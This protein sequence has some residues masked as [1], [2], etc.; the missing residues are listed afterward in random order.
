MSVNKQGINVISVAILLAFCAVAFHAQ[1]N[2][3][4]EAEIKVLEANVAT[5]AQAKD[6]DAVMKNFVPD[7]TL[8]VFDVIPPRQCVGA[9]SFKKNWQGFLDGFKGPVTVENSDLQVFADGKLAY[10]HY[11]QHVAGTGKDGKPI[12]ITFRMTDVLRKI[13]G[14]WLIV[15]E[16]VSVP[17]DIAS[18]KADLSSKP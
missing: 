3:S 6:V 17:V 12:D 14:K 9:D 11:I 18:G 13:G 7:E 5:S 10:A 16:H 2:E 8:I 15:H 4:D 1:A